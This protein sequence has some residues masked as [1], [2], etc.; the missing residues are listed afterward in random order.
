M[1]RMCRLETVQVGGAYIMARACVIGV[2]WISILAIL[3]REVFFFPSYFQLFMACV[4]SNKCGLFQQNTGLSILKIATK[5]FQ[6]RFSDFSALLWFPK[7]SGMS[8]I[9]HV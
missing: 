9:E 8:I 4:Y 7:S 3:K 6:E 5:T 2:V 1:N